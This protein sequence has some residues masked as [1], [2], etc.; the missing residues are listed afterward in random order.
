MKCQ[1]L[2]GG[3]GWQLYQLLKAH[4]LAGFGGGGGGGGLCGRL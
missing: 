4:A 3:S 2:Q 1:L